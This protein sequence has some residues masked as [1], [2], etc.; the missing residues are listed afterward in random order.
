LLLNCQYKR[1]LD[2][3]YYFFEYRNSVLI[4]FRLTKMKGETIKLSFVF[5]KQNKMLKQAKKKGIILSNPFDDIEI[6]LSGCK[7]PN[8]PKDESRVYLPDEKEKLFNQLRKRLMQRPYETDSYVV[9]LLFKLGLRI[10]E[11]VALKWSDIDWNTR[12]IHI[13]RMEGLSDENGKLQVTIFEYT[14]K[15]SPAGDRYHPLSEYEVNLFQTV[16]RIN[17][18]AGYSD[19]DFIFCDEEGR[20]KIREIDNCIRAQCTRAGIEVKSAHDIRRTVASELNRRG[21]PIEDIRWY[22][23][24][25]DIA[26]TQTYILNNQGKQETTKTIVNALS[27]MNGLDVLMSTQIS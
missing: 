12:E 1:L 11:A 18:E 7:P 2:F 14:K 6:N 22:L 24:H 21:V 25:S 19:G 27:D 23:G 15:K 9:F 10:G 26:T 16:K 17:E 4:I 5:L 13:H 20:T 3:F 8:N